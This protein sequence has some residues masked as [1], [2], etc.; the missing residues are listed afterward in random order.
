M[1]EKLITD[2]YTPSLLILA[3]F[4]SGKARNATVEVC[5]SMSMG[6]NDALLTINLLRT[7]GLGVIV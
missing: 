6:E 2:G 5:L 1:I 7:E 3:V 4:P